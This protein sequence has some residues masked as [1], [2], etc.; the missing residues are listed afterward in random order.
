MNFQHLLDQEIV[1]IRNSNTK[2]RL[3]L[4]SCCGP[5]SSSVLESLSNYFE[6][7]VLYF[8]PNI[9]PIQ[10]Y[11]KRLA[12]QQK[13]LLMM[14]FPNKV[15]LMPGEYH[16]DSF[17]QAVKGLENEPENGSR[18]IKCFALRLEETAKMAKDHGYDYFTTT[19]SVSPHKNAELLCDLGGALAEKYDIKFLFSD[20]K[21]RDG[22]KRSIELSEQ[23]GLYRQNYC[24]CEFSMRDENPQT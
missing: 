10:E 19:L 8:N 23:Y 20:F 14:R 22:Y 9:F 21:K 12:E 17:Y 16:R 15:D 7:T 18:C 13:L 3:M 1:S 6:I 11:K 4:H 5:C 2:P 24:G